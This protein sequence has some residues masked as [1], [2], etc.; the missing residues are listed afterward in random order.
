MRLLGTSFKKT[1][2]KPTTNAYATEWKRLDSDVERTIGQSMQGFHIIG[3]QRKGALFVL[4]P[5]LKT[6]D[7][8]GKVRYVELKGWTETVEF[9]DEA[10]NTLTKGAGKWFSEQLDNEGSQL[11]KD[12]ILFSTKRADLGIEKFSGVQWYMTK[13]AVDSLG[14]TNKMI[15]SL[16]DGVKTNQQWFRGHMG[17]FSGDEWKRY[18]KE[19]ETAIRKPWDEFFKVVD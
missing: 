11:F 7:P 8:F 9:V 1:N 2:E 6:A 13:A 14:G 16:M 4:Y 19:L 3:F 17:L 5:V 12:I 15:D 10:G 18:L